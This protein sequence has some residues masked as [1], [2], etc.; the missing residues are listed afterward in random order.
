LAG[1]TAVSMPLYLG[2]LHRLKFVQKP[3]GVIDKA[4]TY[5]DIQKEIKDNKY[6][7]LDT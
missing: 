3:K 1:G 5:A 7:L 2:A 4:G 6:L